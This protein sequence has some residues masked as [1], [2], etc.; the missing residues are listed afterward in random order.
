MRH[1]LS[2]CLE[3]DKADVSSILLLLRQTHTEDDRQ[4]E[5]GIDPKYLLSSKAR[6]TFALQNII[7]GQCVHPGE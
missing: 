1:G 5:L 4:R 2:I 7:L 3:M 6:E